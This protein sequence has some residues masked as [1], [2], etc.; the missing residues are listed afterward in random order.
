MSILFPGN[1][2]PQVMIPCTRHPELRPRRSSWRAV[3]RSRSTKTPKTRPATAVNLPGWKRFGG[4]PDVCFGGRRS[5]L[6]RANR[7]NFT[8]TRRR[9]VRTEKEISCLKSLNSPRRGA[10]GTSKSTFCFRLLDSPLIW[11][12]FGGFLTCVTKMEAVSWASS[13]RSWNFHGERMK[14][15]GES[16][17]NNEF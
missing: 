7:A 12:M 15:R 8:R 3:E 13:E 6:L 1:C 17:R 11:P 14:R 5:P 16:P 4:P 10:S 2:S 9:R